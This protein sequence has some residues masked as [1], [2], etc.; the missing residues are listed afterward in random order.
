MP[1]LVPSQ[2]RENA[3]AWRILDQSNIPFMV[4]FGDSDPITKGGDQEFLDRIK[5]TKKATIKDAGHFIQEDAGPEL[6][7]LIIKFIADSQPSSD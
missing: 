2:L 3:A 7:E 1:Y 4:A 6:A 5:N